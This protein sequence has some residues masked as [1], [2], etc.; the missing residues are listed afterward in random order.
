MLLEECSKKEREADDVI[1][2][3]VTSRKTSSTS[4]VTSWPSS[5]VIKPVPERP[6]PVYPIQS[7]IRP[8][9]LSLKP[10]PEPTTNMRVNSLSTLMGLPTV[11]PNQSMY[12]FLQL[13]LGAPKYLPFGPLLYHSKYPL[14]KKTF[15]C[16]QCRYVTDRKNNL[17]R[18]I[19]TM[20]QDCG[21]PLECCEIHFKSKAA[22]RDHVMMFHRAGYK[23]RFCGRNFCRKALLKRH[24]AVHNGQK[25]FICSVCDYATSHKSNLERHKKVHGQGTYSDD[26]DLDGHPEG[27]ID[28]EGLEPHPLH[29]NLMG[30]HPLSSLPHSHHLQLLRSHQFHHNHLMNL[31]AAANSQSASIHSNVN[32]PFNSQPTPRDKAPEDLSPGTSGSRSPDARSRTPPTQQR[33]EAPRSR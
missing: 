9:A 25:D 21:K 31:A 29:Q 4:N 18:H 16:P 7:V 32:H 14:G 1:R 11:P 6:E 22:L 27:M 15:H 12:P 33:D 26:E 23:C 10:G 2:M 3:E 28:V 19:A 30:L 8:E 13:P 20:H 24:L 17:K 5:N